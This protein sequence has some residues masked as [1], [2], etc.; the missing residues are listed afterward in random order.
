M[1]KLNLERSYSTS[2][3]LR[4]L[5]SSITIVCQFVWRAKETVVGGFRRMAW[6]GCRRLT[7]ARGRPCVCMRLPAYVHSGPALHSP[8]APVA[9]S[10]LGFESP[11]LQKSISLLTDGWFGSHRILP[12]APRGSIY[13]SQ[14]R[15]STNRMWCLLPNAAFTVEGS[16]LCWLRMN[17]LL[18][19]W[20][21]LIQNGWSIGLLVLHRV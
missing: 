8:V 17:L 6:L 14:A 4:H 5:G 10:A 12:S 16:L 9:R 3:I 13:E 21:P 1:N 11:M 19:V 15:G 20:H 7:A 18:L 2:T